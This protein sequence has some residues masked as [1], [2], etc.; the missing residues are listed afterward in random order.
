MS[1]GVQEC[2]C[3]CRLPQSKIKQG[4]E[5]GIDHEMM[6]TVK[7]TRKLKCQ[8]G[9]SIVQSNR[10]KGIKP[11]RCVLQVE[12]GGVRGWRQPACDEKQK[13]MLCLPAHSLQSKSTFKPSGCISVEMEYKKSSLPIPVGNRREVLTEVSRPEYVVADIEQDTKLPRERV[14]TQDRSLPVEGSR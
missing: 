9:G 5:E 10:C 14:A 6:A 8:Y 12:K 2:E 3:K 11:A 1:Y 4:T 13:P 7:L